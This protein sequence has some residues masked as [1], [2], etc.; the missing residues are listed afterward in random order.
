MARGLLEHMSL[1]LAGLAQ[2]YSYDTLTVSQENKQKHVRSSG[3]GSKLLHHF[4]SIIPLAKVT[5]RTQIQ[6]EGK[7]D[8]PFDRRS[9]KVELQQAWIEGKSEEL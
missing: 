4:F 2:P 8:T 7:V 3:L 1:H 6:G 5:R 9:C